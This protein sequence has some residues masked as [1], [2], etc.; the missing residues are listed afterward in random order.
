MPTVAITGASGF[1]GTALARA[2]RADGVQVLRIGRGSDA[3]VRW[4]PNEGHVD[5]TRLSSIDAAVHLAG[6]NIA[7]RW[8]SA[9]KR[10]I[11]ESRVR[12]TSLIARTLAA[13][14]VKPRVLISGSAIGI[15]GNRG[16]EA[17]TESSPLGGDYLAEVAEAW[18]RATDP[19]S[20][21]GIRVALIR[22]GIVL[23]PSGGVLQRLSP[24]FSLGGGGKIGSG[25]QWMSWIARTD[26]VR[27]VR[28]LMD[29]NGAGGVNVVAPDPAT[30]AEFTETLGRV[31]KR[32]TLMTVPEFAVR[33]AFGEMGEA[34]VL[35]SQRVLPERLL[36]AGFQF[37]Y[38]TLASALIHE[39]KQR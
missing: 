21:A 24:I 20:D 27:A 22:T 7:Q 39:L 5:A 34:T 33:L 26:W 35:A 28:F 18:E 1:L 11:R 13:L 4:D 37:Q 19:A 16:D 38:P 8:T 9:R 32:P 15:Y 31:L 3:D 30:N 36:G 6:E 12:G 2:L 29:A 23:H 14:P 17:L 25:K 10:E